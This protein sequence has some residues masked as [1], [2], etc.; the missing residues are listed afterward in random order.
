MR[1][2]EEEGTEFRVFIR[3]AGRDV[4]KASTSSGGIP[5]GDAVFLL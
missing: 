2:S 1:Q 5:Q 4:Q 3:Y